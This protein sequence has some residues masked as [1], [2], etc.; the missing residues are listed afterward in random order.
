[1][2]KLCISTYVYGED[3]Q[4]F[5]PIYIFSILYTYPDYEIRI[6]LDHSLLP[7]IKRQLD[8]I[9]DMGRFSIIENHNS[10]IT[11][12]DSMKKNQQIMRSL[13]WLN[14][15]EDFLNYRAIYIGDID[16]FICKEGKG[17]Y[18]Q[19][20]AHCEY[21]NLPYSNCVRSSAISPFSWKLVM[22]SIIKFGLTETIRFYKCSEKEI[23][24]LTGLHFIRPCEYYESVRPIL[25]K[26]YKKLRNISEGRE[27]GWN[28]VMLN[29]EA[30]LYDLVRSSGLNLPP[31]GTKGA[32]NDSRDV[33]SIS[34]R[35]HH[36]IHLGIFRS[37]ELARRNS[38]LLL[39]EVY[40]GYYRQFCQIRHHEP[41]YK[42][43]EKEFSSY[44]IR[45]IKTMDTF[46]Q[47]NGIKTDC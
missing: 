40:V 6:Y 46:Y 4:S 28:S 24:K 33:N 2:K 31:E 19:H 47:S 39:G 12:T 23:K 27:P 26:C 42:E 8:V 21:L 7:N 38:S 14:Y 34:F 10:R 1:M 25:D 3:Y 43:L 36:G 9:K 37:P 20:M 35:P 29:N 45:L 18:E 22:R 13:R 32:V 41:A 5:I 15:E 44:L 17:L 30:I 11:L 16:I